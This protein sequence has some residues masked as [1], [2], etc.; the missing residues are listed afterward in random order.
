LRE[1][2]SGAVP[3]VEGHLRQARSLAR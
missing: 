2:A 3:V 1:V